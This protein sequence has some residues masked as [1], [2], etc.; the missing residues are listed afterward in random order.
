MWCKSV[1]AALGPL[2][3]AMAVSWTAARFTC[4]CSVC[5]SPCRSSLCQ[6]TLPVA[7]HMKIPAARCDSLKVESL[8]TRCWR[9]NTNS[10]ECQGTTTTVHRSVSLCCRFSCAGRG[11]LIIKCDGTSFHHGVHAGHV[12]VSGVERCGRA[13]VPHVANMTRSDV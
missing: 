6:H 2:H 13:K 10:V 12:T 1:C 8:G 11:V 9:Q 3:V 7:A 5:S 4:A